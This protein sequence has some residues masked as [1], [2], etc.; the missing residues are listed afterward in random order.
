MTAKTKKALAQT[1]KNTETGTRKSTRSESQTVR[2]R[3]FDTNEANMISIHIA[4]CRVAVPVT[5]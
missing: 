1:A 3:I 4:Q 2:E 5:S